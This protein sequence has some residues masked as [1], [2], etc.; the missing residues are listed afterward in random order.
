MAIAKT[1]LRVV[2]TEDRLTA[3]SE[4][5]NALKEHLARLSPKNKETKASKRLLAALE[6]LGAPAQ[7]PVVQQAALVAIRQR[8]ERLKAVKK[9]LEPA[10]QRDLQ[11]ILFFSSGERVS[12]MRE[13]AC[14]VLR[15]RGDDKSIAEVCR[16]YPGLRKIFDQ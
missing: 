14:A 10:Q 2:P 15:L 5:C 3:R 7:D 8:L 16:V 12:E 1:K 11:M 9:D 4:A 6:A 13:Q